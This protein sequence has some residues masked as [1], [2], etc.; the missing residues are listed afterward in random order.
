MARVCAGAGGLSP[1]GE[2]EALQGCE[3][4]E[5]FGHIRLSKSMITDHLCTTYMAAL[6]SVLCR[7]KH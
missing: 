5:Q 3:G 4:S 2:Y 6:E 7:L 1:E